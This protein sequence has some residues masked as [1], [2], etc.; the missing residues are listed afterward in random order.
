MHDLTRQDAMEYLG[1]MAELEKQHYIWAEAMQKEN[2]FIRD[3]QTQKSAIYQ[4]I[5]YISNQLKNYD[6]DLKQ[7][8]RNIEERRRQL[9]GEIEEQKKIIEQ[10]KKKIGI[11][12]VIMILCIAV[13]SVLLV[14][15]A[16]I[17]D[18][19]LTKDAQSVL[20]VFVLPAVPISIG[21]FCGSKGSRTSA[22]K[23]YNELISMETG[24]GNINVESQ[25]MIELEQLKSESDA[26][27]ERFNRIITNEAECRKRQE[28]ISKNLFEVKTLKERLYALNIL[29]ER[30]RKFQAVFSLYDYFRSGQCITLYGHGGAIDTYE[31]DLKFQRVISLLW[32][33]KQ[34]VQD[35]SDKQSELVEEA[36]RAN[37]TL[38][39]IEGNQVRML[40]Y[41]EDTNKTI[42]E[43]NETLYRIEN[44]IRFH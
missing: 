34:I 35:I 44:H 12:R 26:E 30:Y 42:R 36:R 4:K 40:E 27:Q 41:A 22:I 20:V 8:K 3:A 7:R 43:S 10:S 21:I 24:L 28:I 18:L 6:E 2:A 25:K 5:S 31:Q 23:K 1:C 32:D 16:S 17:N 38:Q 39:R 11:T 14:T 29:D 37:S 15:F 9:R 33:I 19:G 13:F